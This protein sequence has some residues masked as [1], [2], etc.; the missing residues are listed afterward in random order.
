MPNYAAVSH[1]HSSALQGDPFIK[2]DPYV[3]YT[4]YFKKDKLEMGP[5]I[6]C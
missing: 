4:N 3:A 2:T 1:Y 6:A 5:I